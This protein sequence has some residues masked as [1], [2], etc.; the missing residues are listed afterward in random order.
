M[1]I[2]HYIAQAIVMDNLE[3]YLLRKYHPPHPHH[4]HQMMMWLLLWELISTIKNKCKNKHCSFYN[5]CKWQQSWHPQHLSLTRR[6]DAL[7]DIE[8]LPMTSSTRTTS[9]KIQG[10]TNI[11]SVKDLECGG[12]HFSESWK[13]LAIIRSTFKWD[14]MR[15]ESMS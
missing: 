15:S 9:L 5:L 1:C 7:G 3:S 10:T 14:T 12:T 11:S 13:H 4:L 8:K 6:R 2:H